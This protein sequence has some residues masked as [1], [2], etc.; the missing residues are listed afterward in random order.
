MPS[1]QR[2]LLLLREPGLDTI[3]AALLWKRQAQLGGDHL[4]A[5]AIAVQ[6]GNSLERLSDKTLELL[7]DEDAAFREMIWDVASP[8][9]SGLA[10]LALL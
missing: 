5:A 8:R 3:A 2:V 7:G 4:L 6:I 10:A 9:L 1:F